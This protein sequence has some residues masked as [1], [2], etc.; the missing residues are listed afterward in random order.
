MTR[1]CSLLAMEAE[2]D[3]S[4]LTSDTCRVRGWGR[5]GLPTATATVT[6]KNP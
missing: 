6:A 4:V 2:E 1:S 3:R 5:L